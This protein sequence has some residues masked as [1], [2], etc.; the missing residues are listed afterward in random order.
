MYYTNKNTKIGAK[1]YELWMNESDFAKEISNKLSSLCKYGDENGFNGWS[2]KQDVVSKAL[3]FNR[4]VRRLFN[5]GDRIVALDRF[6]WK[7]DER[8]ELAMEWF[9]KQIEIVN[10]AYL[11]ITK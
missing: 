8:E 3:K 4:V 9:N 5:D 1:L 11:K 6:Y 7:R 10:K 2:N